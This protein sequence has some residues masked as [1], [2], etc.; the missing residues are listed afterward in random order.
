MGIRPADFLD[1]ANRLLASNAGEADLRSAVSRAY[2]SLYLRFYEQGSAFRISPQVLTVS[3][4]KPIK[5]DKLIRALMD[6]GNTGIR[7]MGEHLQVIYRARI[8]ADYETHQTVSMN[9]AQSIYVSTVTL[10]SAIDQFG[11]ANLAK[12]LEAHLRT[13]YASYLPPGA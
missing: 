9:R 2:Y 7:L 8:A 13:K 10:H 12:E 5:H 6:C 11:L 4:G 3:I 1:T